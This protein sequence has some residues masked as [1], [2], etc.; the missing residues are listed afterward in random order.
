MELKSEQALIERW[1]GK[2]EPLLSVVCLAYNHA[3]FIRK[4]LESFLQ[5]ET[6]FPFE[7]IVHD[8]ASTDTT[9]AIIA[10]Y[11]ARYPSIIKPIYQTQNQF[12]LGVPFS[13]RLF[14][15]AGGKYIAYCEGDDYWTDP[16][17]LQQQVDFL[18]QHRDYVITYHDAFMFNSQGIIQSP[19]LTGKLRKDATA[20]ELMQGRPL[21][22]LTV[23]FRNLIQELPPELLGV[24][25]LDICWWSLLGAYGKGK[26]MEGISPAAYRV[27]EGGIFSMQ[28]SRQRIQMAM[29]AHYS[30]ASYYNRIG[31]NALYEYF[32]IQVFGECLSLIS[33]FSKIQAL[34]TTIAQNIS[35]NL[36]RRLS[37]RLARS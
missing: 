10:D 13:T 32:L 11:A 24:K 28:P 18:E 12:S 31:N 21:S 8:D 30:L 22:T 33:P 2:T 23:C 14:A 26:F 1:G 27:H 20:L 19:Q 9:A 35:L 17:K 5:Q 7:V 36:L 37:P 15:R 16:T 6:D 25:V 34:S 4:A 3:S 29:H